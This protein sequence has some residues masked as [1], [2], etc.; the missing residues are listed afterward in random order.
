M[1]VEFI[2]AF[3][4]VVIS[5]SFLKYIFTDD[6]ITVNISNI[7]KSNSVESSRVFVSPAQQSQLDAPYTDLFQ[8]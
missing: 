5:I 3:S 4:Y 1:P 7:F 2:Q 6:N 8:L